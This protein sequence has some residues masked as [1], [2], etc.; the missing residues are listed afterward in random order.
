MGLAQRRRLAKFL[1]II[2][3]SVL[4]L[5]STGCGTQGTDRTTGS[6]ATWQSGSTSTVGSNAKLTVTFI[7]VGQGDSILVQAPSGKTL[8]VDGGPKD[9]ESAL[10]SAL[11]SKGVK[12]LDNVIATHE[13]ADHIGSLDAAIKAYPVGKVYLPKMPTK[14]T[15]AMEDFLQA[16]K[17]KGISLTPAKAGVN[18]DLGSEVS[19]LMLAPVKASYEEENNYSAV[20]KVNFGKVSFLLTGDAEGHSEQDMINSGADLKSTVLKVGHHGSR[21]STGEAF[22]DAVSPQYAVIQVGHNNYGHPTSQVLNRLAAHGV[23]VYRTDRQGTIT[24]VSDG[25]TVTFSTEK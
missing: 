11:A 12:R 13:D 17:G 10:L 3:L 6:S 15:K 19:A 20:L 9:A 16:V 5:V 7:N 23:K 14:G 8:L 22:L 18:V 4:L 1:V 24:A 25:K 21:Y 2:I